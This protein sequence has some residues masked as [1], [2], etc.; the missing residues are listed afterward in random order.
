M[1]KKLL[2]LASVFSMAFPAQAANRKWESQ[3]FV[4]G[5]IATPSSPTAGKTKLYSKAGSGLYLLNSAGT[6][7]FVAESAAALTAS[8][9]LASDANGRVSSTSVTSTELGYLSGVTSN[10]QSQIDGVS[11]G[12]SPTSSFDVQNVGVAASVSASALT[13]ALKQSDGTDCG[14]GTDAC[15]ISFRNATAA[16]GQYTQV[17]VTGALST[18]ISSGST[19]G[20]TSANANWV[21]L[22]AINN[23]GTVELAWAGSKIYDD[24]SIV[25]TTAEGGAGAADSK[26]T[27]YSTTARTGVASRLIGRIKSTQATAGT[28]ATSPSEISL[29]PFENHSPKCTITYDTGNG[30]GGSSSGESSVRNF[31][32]QRELIGGC[33]TYTARTTTTADKV[34]AN[35]DMG[36]CFQYWDRNSGGSCALGITVDSTELSTNINTPITHAQGMR[37]IGAT[38]STLPGAVSWCGYLK[39]G[40]AVRFQTNQNCNSGDAQSGFTGAR[41]SH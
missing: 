5:Q 33:F 37:V 30:H 27:I 9:A 8:R 21:Y 17:S 19:A 16:T 2:V 32:N 6:E 24:G 34:V 4:L 15:K 1:I 23:A 29:W 3:E 25:T 28:W 20:A 14:A 10:I 13:I 31:T 39:A 11:A 40:Q 36:V 26:T 7:L 18:V 35:T 38:V 12:S 22:Y 41:M